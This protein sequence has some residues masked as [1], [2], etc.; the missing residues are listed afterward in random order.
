MTMKK[1]TKPKTKKP[2]AGTPDY[3][4]KVDR[5]TENRYYGYSSAGAV[6][7]MI[8]NGGEGWRFGHV[9]NGEGYSDLINVYFDTKEK[10]A[11]ACE[12]QIERFQKRLSV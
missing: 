8:E 4:W 2:T 10:A 11:G 3:R 12:A 6:I 9:Y 5:I 7:A 1:K